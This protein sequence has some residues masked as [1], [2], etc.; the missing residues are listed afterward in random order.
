M[1]AKP[2]DFQPLDVSAYKWLDVGTPERL[3]E[4]EAGSW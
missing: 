1:A 3:R 2:A 4:A